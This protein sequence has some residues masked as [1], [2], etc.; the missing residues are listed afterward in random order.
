M[1]KKNAGKRFPRFGQA[2]NTALAAKLSAMSIDGLKNGE[3][4]RVRRC[5]GKFVVNGYRERQGWYRSVD[6]YIEALRSAGKDR[7]Y[8]KSVERTLSEVGEY[9]PVYQLELFK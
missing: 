9:L 5:V 8:V 4:N 6:G 7:G 3:L 1:G 2:I